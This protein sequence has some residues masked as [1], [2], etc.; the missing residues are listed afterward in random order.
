MSS[1]YSLE[2]S[3]WVLSDGHQCAKVSIHFWASLHHFV[4][5]KLATTSMRVKVPSDLKRFE[6]K[7]SSKPWK[8]AI[9]SPIFSS[10]IL[11]IA[12]LSWLH[13]WY[14][15][16]RHACK[17]I[18]R[19]FP[20]FW[21]LK[22]SALGIAITKPISRFDAEQHKHVSESITSNQAKNVLSI[23]PNNTVWRKS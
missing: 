18:Q 9:A 1:W 21:Y 7:T 12:P 6:N 17:I 23:I 22:L 11:V 4:L 3:R 20:K 13:Y 15:C 8:T 19:T 5:A 14:T 2:S 10:M 16:L